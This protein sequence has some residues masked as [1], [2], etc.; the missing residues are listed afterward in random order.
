MPFPVRR[1]RGITFLGKR[2]PCRITKRASPL[3]CRGL[4]SSFDTE[5]SSRASVRCAP[6]I[7]VRGN[8]ASR[9]NVGGRGR[10]FLFCLQRLVRIA[11]LSLQKRAWAGPCRADVPC[12]SFLSAR[13]SSRSSKRGVAKR[14]RH[15]ARALGSALYLP[16]A[17]GNACRLPSRDLIRW[18]ALRHKI[19]KAKRSTGSRRTVRP[20]QFRTAKRDLRR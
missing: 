12:P 11:P 18:H 13:R 15:R 5:R 1:V 2:G 4:L 8:G 19:K 16:A 9:R 17:R 3:A 20:R 14:E 7:A 10:R 6:C